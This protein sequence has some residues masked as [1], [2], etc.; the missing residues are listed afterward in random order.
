MAKAGVLDQGGWGRKAWAGTQGEE[1]GVADGGPATSTD[2]PVTTAGP[3]CGEP[4]R[5]NARFQ[6][7]LFLNTLFTGSKPT[8]T[9]T[10]RR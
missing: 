6:T 3:L 8:V 10:A 1:G 7:G 9:E 4:L 5:H 2:R